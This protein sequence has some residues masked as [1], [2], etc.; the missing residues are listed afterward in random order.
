MG[1][2]L[3]GHKVS[4]TTEHSSGRKDS[5]KRNVYIDN[6]HVKRINLSKMME[7]GENTRG[8]NPHAIKIKHLSNRLNGF[9]SLKRL[10]ERKTWGTTK[11]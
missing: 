10:G 2:S 6:E 5:R 9:C 8:Q 11:T 1:C 3:W 4:D 7:P